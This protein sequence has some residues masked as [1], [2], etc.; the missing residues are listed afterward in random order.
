M[1]QLT[2][3]TEEEILLS[4]LLQKLYPDLSQGKIKKLYQQSRVMR[5]NFV[6][7]KDCQLKKNELIS[8]LKKPNFIKD[9]IIY[10]EDEDIVVLEKPA[11]TL[12]VDSEK[13]PGVSIHSTLKRYYGSVFPVQ[14]LDRETTGVMV[15]AL[16]REAKDSFR[17]QFM[18][19]S[20]EREYIAV[21]HGAIKEKNGIWKCFL[22]ECG[23]MKMR[24]SNAGIEAITHYKVNKTVG[25]LYSFISCKLE[26]GK[27]NQIRVQ[28]AHAGHPII[29][30][31]R[32]GTDQKNKTL[33]L[34]AHKL[35]FTH[36][37]TGKRLS[38]ISPIP[39]E[40][41]KKIF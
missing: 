24:V 31:S 32:Y 12:S 36:P 1:I 13:N 39:N 38:F 21:V 2:T 10:Y 3:T 33:F 20:V 25:S 7:E 30:D 35:A 14:R 41:R 28:S 8:I 18:D 19:K 15:F 37:R 4:D 22:K 6:A 9:M 27:K 11:F 17:G 16:T 23:D 40:F 26:T 5:N 29:G 34:H